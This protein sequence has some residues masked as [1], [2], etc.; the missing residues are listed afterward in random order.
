MGAYKY[1]LNKIYSAEIEISTI[2]DLFCLRVLKD[3]LKLAEIPLG[4]YSINS[5]SEDAVCIEYLDG[6]WIV[7]NGERENKYNISKFNNVVNAC[8]EL[9]SRL[10][11]TEKEKQYIISLFEKN[12]N[13]NS[14]FMLWKFNV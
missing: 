1:D 5:Y 9:I 13:S 2:K 8:R 10:S 11:D 4:Y 7:Y 12:I 14:N 3:V 6:D